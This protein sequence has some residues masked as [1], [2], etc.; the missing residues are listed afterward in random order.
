M[1]VWNWEKQ[2]KRE[3]ERIIK[4]SKQGLDFKKGQMLVTEK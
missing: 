3:P 4:E 2:D 1:L